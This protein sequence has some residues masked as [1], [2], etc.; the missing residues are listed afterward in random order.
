MNRIM[1]G[2]RRRVQGVS[3]EGSERTVL[4]NCFVIA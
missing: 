1:Q 2:S 3:G 4:K